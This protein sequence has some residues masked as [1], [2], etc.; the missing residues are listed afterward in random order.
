MPN[1]I[2]QLNEE[3]IKGQ[4]KELVRGSVEETLN[5]LL[6]AEAEK[7]TQAARYE[8]SEARQGYRS[9]HY[10]RNL[11]TTSGDVTLHVPRLKGISF[12]TAII[13][14][15]RRRE[16]S[17]EEALIEMY[18]AGVSVRQVE[19]ITE[20]LWGSKV[21]A[22]TISE[23]N[24][25]AYVNIEAWRNRHLQ[26]GKYPYV[27][28]DGIYLKR[29]WG[30]EYENVAVLVA[31]AVNKDGYREVLGAAEGMKEDKAS[32]VSFFQ[33]LRGR[34]LE[35]VKLI[36]GDKCLGMLEAVG[37]VFPEAKYQ[38]CVV[39][40]YRNIFSVVPKSKVKNVA[41]MLKAIHAQE[42]KKAS[43]EKAAAVV[44]ELKAM[45]LPEAA[46]KVEAGIE[47]TLTYC[48]FPS[49]HWVKIR[50]NNV[51]ERMNREIRRRTRVVGAFP[52]GNSALMLVCARLRHVAGTQ[53]GCKK[54]MNMKR[55]WKPWS[56]SRRSAD[57]SQVTNG[58]GQDERRTAALDPLRPAC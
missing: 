38:R 58:Q 9:G 39:H 11:T 2:V 32:W 53:W 19:D 47:E 15:Y 20:A 8:R 55:I 23:L 21:S 25:K 34:G 4:I 45:K 36:V 56:R 49:E 24:K 40:F 3:I 1:N 16:S 41:K 14:R 54:Y 48:D 27:Y 44:S 29:N 26:G 6:E 43:R 5:E 17:V 50:T 22:S 10:D 18:L 51:I 13:E 12:E 37:E 52:D 7:L 28:V 57:S 35:G 31:I 30:G 42:S 46:K 33:W